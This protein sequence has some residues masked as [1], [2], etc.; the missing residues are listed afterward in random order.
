MLNSGIKRILERRRPRRVVSNTC[1]A[2]ES[3]I[4]NRNTDIPDINHR[5]LK[6]RGLSTNRKGYQHQNP[7]DQRGRTA[8]YNAPE[9][10][11]S[12]W[13]WKGHKRT[14]ADQRR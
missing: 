9:Y 14:Q 11:C 4:R 10:V 1:L 6:Q 7:D 3:R 8:S 5:F 12:C 13:C 2:D